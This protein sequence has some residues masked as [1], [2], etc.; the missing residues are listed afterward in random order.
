MGFLFSSK[1]MKTKG[2]DYSIFAPGK[3]IDLIFNG[4]NKSKKVRSAVIFECYHDSKKM[5]I[6]QT[7][8]NL[9]SKEL[10]TLSGVTTLV[11][12]ELNEMNRVGVSCNII[13][14]MKN[15]QL[16]SGNRTTAMLVKYTE[17]LKKVNVR[18]SYRFHPVGD[19]SAECKVI[20]DGDVFSSHK[21]FK[22]HNIS[23]HGMGMLIPIAASFKRAPLIN[24]EVNDVL[25]I[26]LK[27]KGKKEEASAPIRLRAQIVW[28]KRHYNRKNYIWGIKFKQLDQ[29]QEEIISQF[30]HHGQ[31]HFIR[32]Q[33][34]LS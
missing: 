11:D 23:I 17:P 28:Q 2:N 4:R 1:Q 9:S 21:D 27:L 18:E 20:C 6:S 10:N 13:N 3:K 32:K 34:H 14:F 7:D 22:I 12:Q 31:L 29:Q 33:N 16:Y 5:V 24:R 8:P 15:Y 30:V 26:E 25:D 19:F